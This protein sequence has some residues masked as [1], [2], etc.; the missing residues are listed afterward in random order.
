MTQGARG[1]LLRIEH[2][3]LVN[4]ELEKPETSAER[5]LHRYTADTTW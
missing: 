3:D 4:T 2:P 5:V 1:R